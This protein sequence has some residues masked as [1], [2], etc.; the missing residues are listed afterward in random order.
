MVEQ[1]MYPYLEGKVEDVMTRDPVMVN[2]NESIARLKE[3]FVSYKYHG[4]P[5]VNDKG[6]LVGIVRDNEVL[7]IFAKRGIF[8]DSIEIIK[9]IMQV[10]PLTISPDETI[11]KAVI[12]MFADGTRFLVVLDKDKSIVGVVTRIDLIRGIRWRAEKP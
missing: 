1:K 3:C 7:S 4:L 6:S 5:V 2:E 10:P 11:Q 8:G 12:K 9:D